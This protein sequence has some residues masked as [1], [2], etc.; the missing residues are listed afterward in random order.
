MKYF[1]YSILLIFFV[2]LFNAC[3]NPL[4][5]VSIKI[6]DAL[7]ESAINLTYRNAVTSDTTLKPKNIK[8]TFLGED[9]EGIVSSV[10]NNKINIS[11]EGLLGIAISPEYSKRPANIKV[12]AQLEGYLTDINQVT[13]QG[14]S[15]IN[16]TIRI[17]NI[18]NL[19]SGMSVDLKELNTKD[20][21]TQTV[22]LLT[23]GQKEKVSLVANSGTN[24]IDKSGTVLSGKFEMLLSHFE[25]KAREF[26][27][28]NY[29]VYQAIGIDNKILPPFEFQSYGF[30][31]FKIIDEK[32][33]EANNLSK[34]CSVSIEI[35]EDSY[36]TNGTRLKEGDTIP[37]WVYAN[38][39]WKM[40][41]NP[42]LKR[43]ANGKL[44]I[45]TSISSL[46]YYALG[47][48][49]PVCEKGPML[50]VNS[51]NKG[52]D[53]YHYSRL[54]EKSS[55]KNV[56]DLYLSL[57]NGA[58]YSLTGRR[59]NT[60]YLQVFNYNNQYGGDLSKPIFQT[61]PFDLCEE[62]TI[63]V[64]IATPS[65][66]P[67]NVELIIECA[68]GQVVNNE[69]VPAKVDIQFQPKGASANDWR[70]LMTLTRNQLKGSTYKLK[71]GSTY[72]I[73]ASPNPA[74]GW[75]FYKRDT[76]INTYNYRFYI[77]NKD[78]CK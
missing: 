78:Y 23:N 46:S 52:L 68:K 20:I 12:V 74:Q 27:P 70:D 31:S 51:A 47:E 62:K 1:G 34:P 41:D 8:F 33:E 28:S 76:L 50:V 25:N 61:E 59:K 11:R 7:T 53:I 48:M 60:V 40:L 73:R 37:F 43:N 39:T 57:N 63:P 26:V 3:N 16:R 18:N 29:T 21:A 75:L 5:N 42:I 67:I 54:I 10:G 15:N 24:V 13:I 32:F 36:H 55:G 71:Y 58:R 77:E 65:P 6:K 9:A 45:T 14:K 30:F 69:T 35:N 17:F 72:S 22:S 38:N 4:E 64:N 44:S 56:G 49:F 66:Q 2:S 19:P